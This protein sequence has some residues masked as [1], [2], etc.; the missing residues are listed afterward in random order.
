MKSNKPTKVI[1][2]TDGG[3]RGNPGPSAIGVVIKSRGGEILKEYGEK[4][5]IATN[6]I[7]E[8]EA[9]V[10]ALKKLRQLYGKTHTKNMHVEFRMDSKLIV[11]QLSGIYKIETESLFKSFITIWNLKMDFGEVEF[12]HVPRAENKEADAQVNYALDSGEQDS[13]L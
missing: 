11:S 8:Y 12:H 4:I 2:Y 13:L 1:V 9:V 7:A 6:N 5:G 10:F 3:S